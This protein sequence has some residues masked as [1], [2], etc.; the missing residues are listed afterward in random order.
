MAKFAIRLSSL[1]LQLSAIVLLATI[2]GKLNSSIQSNTETLM[3]HS[4]KLSIHDQ[5]FEAIFNGRFSPEFESKI[6][7]RLNAARW[8][9]G[10]DGGS[11]KTPAW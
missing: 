9:L 5:K 6:K 2:F 11:S 10:G 7:D 4:R 3:V 8:D 1:S